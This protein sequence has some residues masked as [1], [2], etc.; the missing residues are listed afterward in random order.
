MGIFHVG[1]CGLPRGGFAYSSGLE[2]A[3]QLKLIRNTHDIRQYIESYTLSSLRILA[4][5]MKQSHEWTSHA[6]LDDEIHK[7]K[8]HFHNHDCE[9]WLQSSS[10]TRLSH[11]ERYAHALLL[12]NE[13]AYRTSLDQG[14]SLLRV[15]SHWSKHSEAEWNSIPATAIESSMKRNVLGLLRQHGIS[16][17][18]TVW[19]VVTRLWGLDPEDAAHVLGYCLARDTVSAAVR[20]NLIGPLAS[21]GLL[22]TAQQAAI[23]GARSCFPNQPG[24][25]QSDDPLRDDDWWRTASSCAPVIDTIQPNHDLLASRLFRS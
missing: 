18:A 24:T 21:V 11:I 17:L 4:P 1:R 7:G 13:P 2:A 23:E 12:S 25:S 20:L 9:S 8:G 5:I 10:A 19:G 14:T 15:A 22:H 16:H 3:H 6:I